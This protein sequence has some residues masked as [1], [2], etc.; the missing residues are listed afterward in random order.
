[1]FVVGTN[2]EKNKKRGRRRG[3]SYMPQPFLL[4]VIV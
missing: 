4:I 1:M 3:M 2:H